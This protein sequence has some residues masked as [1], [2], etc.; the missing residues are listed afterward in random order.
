LRK[1]TLSRWA[2]TYRYEETTVTDQEQ[3]RALIEGWAAAVRAS[4]IGGILANHAAEMVMF[5]VPPPIES[6]GL[7]AYRKTWE[8]TFFPWFRSSGIFHL[9]EL[10]ISAGREVAFA[11]CLVHCGGT[12]KDETHT[13]LDVRLTMCF[14]KMSGKWMVVHEHHSVP[15]VD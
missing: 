8:D 1:T 12:E 7:E 11:H 9:G 5:D 4:D 15:A 2:A 13:E 3:I 10:S 6:R 14:K